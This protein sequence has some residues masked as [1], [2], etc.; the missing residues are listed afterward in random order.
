[1]EKIWYEKM[2]SPVGVLTLVESEKGLM[3][4]AFENNDVLDPLLKTGQYV[5]AS[6]K[7]KTQS[8]IKQLKE[9]FEGK[10]TSFDITFDI[11]EGGEFYKK[12]WE[13]LLTIPYGEVRSY[14]QMAEALGNKKASRAVGN[15]NAHNPI[16]IIIP[17][18]RVINTGGGLG[19]F[20]GG[21]EA[22]KILLALEGYEE[23]K[24]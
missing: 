10:R 21:L 23:Y 20:G 6:S 17:C 7:L 22:K 1:M 11:K 24:R 9:Y 12:E 4:L 19:G 3:C 2:Q 18:H 13:A 16:A 14:Q 15:A 5:I 8:I